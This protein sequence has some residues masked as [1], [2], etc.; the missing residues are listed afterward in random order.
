MEAIAALLALTLMEIVLG[1]DNVIFITILTDR[2][3]EDQHTAGTAT[4][5]F[6]GNALQNRAAVPDQ[7]NHDTG[8]AAVYIDR[9]GAV[10]GPAAADGW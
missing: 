10:C 4:G 1:I 7:H 2:L 3:P 9:S 6:P 8:E 5:S